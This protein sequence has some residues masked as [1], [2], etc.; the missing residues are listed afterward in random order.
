MIDIAVSGLVKAYEVDKN[1]L[2]GLSF[3]I[4]QGERVGI[5]G[6]NGAGKTTLFKILTDEI[7]YDEGDVIL[8][9]GKR[10]GMISQI[11]RFPKGYTVRQVLFFAFS[12]LSA[13]KDEMEILE[14]QMQKDASDAVLRRYDAMARAFEAEGGYDAD[15]EYNKICNGLNIPPMMQQQEFAELSGGEQTRVNLGRL[16]LEKT[17]IMLLDEPTNHLDMKATMWLEEYLNKYKGTVLIISHDR[18]FLDHVASRIIELINGKAEY[19]NGNYSFYVMEKQACYERQLKQYQQEQAKLGQLSETAAKLRGW[20]TGNAK[21]MKRAFAIEKRMERIAKTERPTSEKS[22]KSRFGE[23]E[24]RGDEVLV[25]KNLAKSYG[26]K[27]LFSDVNLEVAAGERIALIGENGT[28]KTTFINIL[29]DSECGDSGIVR[30]GP[31]VKWAYLPQ[32]VN[33]GHPERSMLDTLIYELNCSTQTARNRLGAFKFQGEDVFKSVSQLS[34]GERSRLKLCMLMNDE[35]N[36]LILDEPT[37]HLDIASREWME[38]ALEDYEEALLFVS[39]DRYFIQRFATRI[40]E[41]SNGEIR[42]FRGGYEEYQIALGR[43]EQTPK[44]EIKIERKPKKRN[45]REL[46]KQIAQL[47]REIEKCERQ[48]KEYD[49]QALEADSDYQK[50]TEIYLG[51]E[52]TEGEMELLYENWNK[53]MEERG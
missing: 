31:S 52:K 46:D 47:E 5:L 7:G 4:N 44:A 50:L 39:H 18:Y 24:F 27:G 11:P 12:R 23:K 2:D 10:T 3:E 8:A 51:K 28:G 43:E 37:N 13:L 48:L 20:G 17:D 9:P 21:L 35:I 42:D 41:L 25:I 32:I 49:Q 14:K 29:S 6:K 30:F 26:Q 34:G 22:I 45:E 16:I 36:L 40:W 33:F 53:L 38:E 15:T 19:Y 1:I